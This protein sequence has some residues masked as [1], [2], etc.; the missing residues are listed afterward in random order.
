MTVLWQWPSLASLDRWWLSSAVKPLLLAAPL[1][2][3]ERAALS[4]G[5]PAR[6]SKAIRSSHGSTAGR[7]SGRG[8]SSCC[9]SFA[10]APSPPEPS[11]KAPVAAAAAGAAAAAPSESR[12]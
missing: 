3:Y 8:G 11:S 10:A 1:P 4:G 6:M 9:S 2:L 12:V 7:G 5:I